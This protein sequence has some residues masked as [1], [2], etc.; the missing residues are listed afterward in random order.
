MALI[1]F[2]SGYESIPWYFQLYWKIAKYRI[3]KKKQ[4]KIYAKI[5]PNLA[6]WKQ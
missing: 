3:L 5:N 6:D 2:N 4:F 1:S